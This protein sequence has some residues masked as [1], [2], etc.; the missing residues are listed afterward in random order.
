MKEVNID[1]PELSRVQWTKE[2]MDKVRKSNEK[3]ALAGKDKAKNPK[4]ILQEEAIVQTDGICMQ[5]ENEMDNILDYE[6][7]L[8]IDEEE[9]AEETVETSDPGSPRPGTSSEV[10]KQ[11]KQIQDKNADINTDFISQLENQAEEKLMGNPVIQRMMQKFFREEFQNIQKQQHNSGTV[12][13]VQICL[14]SLTHA[15]PKEKMEFPT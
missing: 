11:C 10:Q 15:K 3:A 8:S 9:I 14:T 2:F 6:D 13:M 12:K 7:D 1:N 4:L 5:I